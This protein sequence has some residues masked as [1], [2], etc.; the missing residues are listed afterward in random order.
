MD[1]DYI[2]DLL[3]ELTNLGYGIFRFWEIE[4]PKS[5]STEKRILEYLNDYDRYIFLRGPFSSEEQRD[6][7]FKKIQLELKNLKLHRVSDWKQ[8]LISKT[9]SWLKFRGP[10]S[11]KE[12]DYEKIEAVKN[13]VLNQVF[14]FLEINQVVEGYYIDEKFVDYD[15][16]WGDQ[17]SFNIVL[18]SQGMIYI[19]HCGWSS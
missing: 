14:E 4:N 10:Y 12:Y 9:D 16:P 8:L 5:I 11:P 3:D 6:I 1:A 19:Y 7:R 17:M 13:K 15:T 18:S 2:D